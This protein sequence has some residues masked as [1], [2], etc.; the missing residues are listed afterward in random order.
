MDKRRGHRHGIS[1]RERLQVKVKERSRKREEKCSVAQLLEKVQECTESC[2]VEMARIFCERALE[3]APDDPQVLDIAGSLYAE[4]GLD[5]KAKSCLLH[6]IDL[7]PDKGHAKYM[8]L[9]QLSSAQEAVGFFSKGVE[10]MQR[11]L[12]SQSTRGACAFPDKDNITP[13]EVSMAY[14]CIA[15]I[16]LTDLCIQ[17]GAAERCKEVLEKALETSPN[18]VEALQLMA[19]FLISSEK[20]QEGKRF[21]MQSLEVWLPSLMRKNTSQEQ[22]EDTGEDS[23]EWE[24]IEDE[25]EDIL[26]LAVEV[27]EH[28]LEEQDDVVQVWYLLGW[29]NFLQAK[30]SSIKD[31]ADHRESSRT[32]L[33]QAK[34]LTEKQCYE[35]YELVSHIEE[36]LG[37]LGPARDADEDE[38]ED[39]VTKEE[40]EPEFELSSEDDNQMD[41]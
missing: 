35:D 8:Y 33:L 31:E 6:A 29:V 27:L 2:D 30:Q 19:S 32:A 15:E 18:N 37:E 5:D 34:K 14:C 20:P 12:V 26:Q 13:E 40:L 21:L 24:D 38:D 4:L 11:S 16:Y 23:Q 25:D 36:L 22:S 7:T 3:T 9:G 41:L 17:E 10:L 28:L 39:E 1:T